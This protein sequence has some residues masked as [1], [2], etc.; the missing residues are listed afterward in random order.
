VDALAS[1][2]GASEAKTFSEV[3]RHLIFLYRCVFVTSFLRNNNFHTLRTNDI[4]ISLLNKNRN[5]YNR[6]CFQVKYYDWVNEEIQNK[7]NL[8]AGFE[9]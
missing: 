6:F 1:T 2:C 5:F 4:L 3:L 7:Q 8:L 9:T